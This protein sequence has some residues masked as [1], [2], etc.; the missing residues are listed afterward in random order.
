MTAL[1]PTA[2][3]FPFYLWLIRTPFHSLDHDNSLP[4]ST[5]V[6]LRHS[7]CI[8][9]WNELSNTKSRPLPCLTPFNLE[10]LSFLSQHPRWLVSW[11][12][13]VYLLNSG[14]WCMRWRFHLDLGLWCGAQITAKLHFLLWW[15]SLWGN[16]SVLFYHWTVVRTATVHCSRFY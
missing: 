3:I 10:C 12:L 8:G 5:L 16:Q 6:P 2:W 4:D 1:P 11:L 14:S 15:V 9:H 7:L 13:P